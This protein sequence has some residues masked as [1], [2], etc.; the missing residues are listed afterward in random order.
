MAVG[1]RFF[2]NRFS[3]AHLHYFLIWYSYIRSLD[4]SVPAPQPFTLP[5]RMLRYALW[6][7]VFRPETHT[8]TYQLLVIVIGN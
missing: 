1:I 7:V 8:I 4:Q 2:L 5:E 6:L 3:T